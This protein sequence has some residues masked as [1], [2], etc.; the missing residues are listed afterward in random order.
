[1]RVARMMV[2]SAA[3]VAIDFAEIDRTMILGGNFRHAD[4]TCSML[5]L[6]TVATEHRIARF[7]RTSVC[8]GIIDVA[9][10]SA[11]VK[12]PTTFGDEGGGAVLAM[13]MRGDF[14]ARFKVAIH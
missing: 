8:A 11:P 3:V 14:S 13:D 5:A 1:M 7:A 6:L 12:S 4:H 10:D 9:S 2:A